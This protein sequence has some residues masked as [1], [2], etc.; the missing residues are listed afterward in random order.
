MPHYTRELDAIFTTAIVLFELVELENRGIRL[1]GIALSN[2]ENAKQTQVIQLPLFAYSN[3][4][5]C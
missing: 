4:G 1:L 5:N 2:L 3:S